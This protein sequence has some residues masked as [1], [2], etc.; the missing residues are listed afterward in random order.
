MMKR[1]RRTYSPG[2]PPGTLPA[3]EPR[4]DISL[5]IT[6]TDYSP[7]MVSSQ[8][9]DEVPDWINDVPEGT[10]RWL[11]LSGPPSR[12]VLTRLGSAFGIHPLVLED[13][14]STEQRIK[15]DEYEGYAYTVL[16]LLRLAG[17][18][19]G[20]TALPVQNAVDT[21]LDMVLTERVLITV[22]E[23][24]QPALFEPI[25]TRLSNDGSLL[26]RGTVDLL[27]Y[28]VF[29]LMVDGFFPVIAGYES[30]MENLESLITDGPRQEHVEAIHRLLSGI[31]YLRSTLWSMRDVTSAIER[32]GVYGMTNSTRF[33]FRDIHDHVV[34]LLDSVS[35][36]RESAGS[37][38]ELHVS[39]MSN[40]MNEIMK[41]LTVISTTFIPITF[42]AGVYGMNFLHMPE[43]AFRW[44]Y[45]VVIGLMIAIAAGMVVYFKRRKWF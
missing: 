23:G 30:E 43:L 31:R 28:A 19:A 39:G 10:V 41:V 16:R 12:A 35:D 20:S 11:R 25:I 21:E 24:D 38:R 17:E 32:S 29:D 27:Y 36:L 42:I 33:Y 34:H 15:T 1:H 6:V 2:L 22:D 3:D 5:V 14:A 8:E 13:I 45:P 37:L 18:N 44:A 40:H 9:L 26:R 4:G 7:E